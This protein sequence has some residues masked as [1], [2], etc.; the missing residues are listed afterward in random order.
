LG[1]I[2]A[3]LALLAGAIGFTSF[4]FE[5]DLGGLIAFGLGF[6]GLI[7]SVVAV[8]WSASRTKIAWISLGLSIAFW[9]G[10]FLVETFLGNIG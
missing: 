3:A 4:L 1:R 2:A 6:V 8:S 9:I 7:I 10:G 5:L